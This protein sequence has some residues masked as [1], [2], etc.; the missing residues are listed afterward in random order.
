MTQLSVCVTRYH[1]TKMHRGAK[2]E[3]HSTVTLQWTERIGWLH[4]PGTVCPRR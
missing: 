1:T 3:L 2:A 4:T